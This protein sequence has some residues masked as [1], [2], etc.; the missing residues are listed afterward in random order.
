MQKH[1]PAHKLSL[2]VRT[3]H[4]RLGYTRRISDLIYS[5]F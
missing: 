2:T 5:W 3:P 4:I 1:R